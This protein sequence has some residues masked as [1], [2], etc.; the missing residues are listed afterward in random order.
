MAKKYEEMTI[1]ELEGVL[2]ELDGK[3]QMMKREAEYVVDLLNFRTAERM[4]EGLPDTM[5]N[6]LR[7]ILGPKGIESGEKFGVPGAK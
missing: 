4:V 5:R 2:G 7:T 3:V 6:A 1:E